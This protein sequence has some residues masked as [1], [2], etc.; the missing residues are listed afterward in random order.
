MHLEHILSHRLGQQQFSQTLIED[1]HQKYSMLS[2]NY[3]GYLNLMNNR[4]KSF[5][6]ESSEVPYFNK[7]KQPALDLIA[8][9]IH[10][11]LLEKPAYEKLSIPKKAG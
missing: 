2:N 5:E 11:E 10:V 8:N 7:I 9:Q 1:S 6:L 3:R 4:V